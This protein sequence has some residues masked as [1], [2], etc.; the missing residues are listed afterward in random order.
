M[1]QIQEKIHVMKAAKDVE[2]VRDIAKNVP[3]SDMDY[4]DI[5]KYPVQ[6][7]NEDK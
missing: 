6:E 2:R 5:S 1:V 7:E 4:V 3:L